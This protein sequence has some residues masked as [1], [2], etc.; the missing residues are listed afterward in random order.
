MKAKTRLISALLVALMVIT[1]LPTSAF[2]VEKDTEPTWTEYVIDTTGSGKETPMPTPKVV[3]PPYFGEDFDDPEAEEEKVD[4][5][6]IKLD[7]VVFDTNYAVQLKL[8]T[9]DKD[10]YTLDGELPEGIYF[11]EK[12]AT[13]SG[14]ALPASAGR[15]YVFTVSTSVESKT[16]SMFVPY[17]E[18]SEVAVSGIIVPRVKAEPSYIANVTFLAGKTKVLGEQE[19]L[20]LKWDEL[21]PK[22]GYQ[23]FPFF[24]YGYTYRC[25][26]SV[27][28]PA[29]YRIKP[30]ALVSLNGYEARY[31]INNTGSK[32]EI[33]YYF[34]SCGMQK[35]N[36]AITYDFS[37]EQPSANNKNPRSVEWK[38]KVEPYNYAPVPVNPDVLG[39]IF[40]GW[41]ED[42]ARQK[43]YNFDT[44]VNHNRVIYA[45]WIEILNKVE[46][47][48][49]NI[50]NS[51]NSVRPTISTKDNAKYRVVGSDWITAADNMSASKDV[52]YYG[53]LE[54]GNTYT[55][56]VAIQPLPTW[57]VFPESGTSVK[58]EANGVPVQNRY[59]DDRSTLYIY[60][61]VNILNGTHTHRLQHFKEVP[62]I[63]RC[64]S[65]L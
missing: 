6:A 59:S 38:Y 58:A 42:S 28:L 13:V 56:R 52:I 65:R 36:Y 3:E 45:K 25:V 18:L 63:L 1:I 8:K 41:Y 54:A 60:F 40:G 14:K 15:T 19:T 49:S 53:D 50:Y 34:A 2:A 10:T 35:T 20:N 37:T 17:K 16:Y 24:K 27:L 11:N 29:G 64:M 12:N 21:T 31:F 48:T 30:G 61:P 5:D 23:P 4:P 39:Y 57:G 22:D 47:S 7:D 62:A 55:L 32:M 33:V 46:I 44:V 9:A 51:V 43:P 26:V